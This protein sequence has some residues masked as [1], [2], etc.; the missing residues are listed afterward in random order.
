MFSNTCKNNKPN[1]KLIVNCPCKDRKDLERTETKYIREFSVKY[2]EKLLN[3]K[4]NLLCK[5]KQIKHHVEID[6]EEQL[7]IRAG[8]EKRIK[9][10]EHTGMF[11][12]D[13]IVHNM[14][15]VT[16]ARFKILDQKE[17]A[18]KQISERK[19]EVIKKLMVE[20]K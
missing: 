16:E 8:L 15:I 7:K 20:F 11:A 14:R 1:I 5:I 10:K 4:C 6:N 18:Y 9:I 12:I 19:E 17:K 2:G 3:K 13:T